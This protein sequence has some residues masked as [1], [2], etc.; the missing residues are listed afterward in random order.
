MQS[1]KDVL[2]EKPLARDL[3]QAK[4]MVNTADSTK[5][6]LKCGFNHRYH[7]AVCEAYKIFSKGLIGRPLFGRGRYG[8]QGRIGLKKEWRSNRKIVGGGQLM[9]QGIHLIDLFHWFLGKF[10]K[11]TGFVKTNYWPIQ[12]LEDNAFAILETSS[13]ACISIHSSLTQWK[14]LFDFEIYGEKGYLNVSGLGGS[15]GTE[16][17]I[18]GLNTPA[19]PFN[20][21]TIEYRQEDIS[22]KSEWNEFKNSISSRR[23]PTGNGQDGLYAMEVVNKIYKSSKT[24]RTEFLTK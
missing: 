12:P 5:R 20:H 22:W 13:G 17:L 19:S 18:F 14:N 7:P 4:L 10:H 2:C 1:E 23:E 24:N 16:K 3:N 21:K 8:I 11:V 9:E 6:I 15:Y